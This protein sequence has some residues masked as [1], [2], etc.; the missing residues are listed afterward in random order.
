MA[1][2]E[3]LFS[4]ARKTGITRVSFGFARASRGPRAKRAPMG[5]P[6]ELPQPLPLKDQDGSTF[7]QVTA[8]MRRLLA[9]DGCAWLRLGSR[10]EPFHSA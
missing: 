7:P 8:L 10:T 1:W 4:P 2:D 9:D 6:F 5:R 3:T